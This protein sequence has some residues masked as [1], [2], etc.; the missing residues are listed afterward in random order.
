MLFDLIDRLHNIG[1]I[2]KVVICDQGGPNR[3][4][5]RSLQL[6]HQRKSKTY[7]IRNKSKI[8]F[9]WDYPH[10]LK[11]VRNMLLKHVVRVNRRK[12]DFKYVREVYELEK[13]QLC[14]STKLTSRHMN[15]NSLEK[16]KVSYAT[17]TLS[18]SVAGAVSTYASLRYQM[19]NDLQRFQEAG[20]TAKFIKDMNGIFDIFDNS[21]KDGALK[22]GSEHLKKLKSFYLPMFQSLELVNPPKRVAKSSSATSKSK[23][24]NS[25]KRK[26]STRKNNSKGNK[27]LKKKKETKYV[28]PCI[29]GWKFNIIS[30]IEIWRDLNSNYKFEH[31]I[32]NRLNQDCIENYFSIIRGSNGSNDNPTSARFQTLINA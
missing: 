23:H 20:S 32:Q 1:L 3:G 11:S 14:R 22:K 6:S 5:F 29:N 28:L 12:V 2:P 9:S 21:T 31:L 30:L 19:D 16:M 18:G 17:Q 7:I 24:A 8:H 25:K 15:P 26:G 10:L 27:A 4:L 13:Y